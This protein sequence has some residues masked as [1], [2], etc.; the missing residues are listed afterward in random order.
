MNL[1]AKQFRLYFETVLF[2]LLFIPVFTTTALASPDTIK[3]STGSG[4][5]D[6][7]IDTLNNRI[8]ISCDNRRNNHMQG[9]IWMY[10]TQAGKARKLLFETPLGFNFHP[11]GIFMYTEN[12]VSYLYVINHIYKDKSEIDRFIVREQNLKLDKRITDI[13]GKPND[14][15]VTGKDE[16]YYTD[17]K[18]TGGSI[19]RYSNGQE[20]KVVK[21]LKMPN[22]IILLN[23]TLYFT[24]TLNGRLYK[25]SIA[26]FEKQTVCKLK[27]GDN[28]MLCGDDCFL[29]ASHQS[30]GKFRKHAKHPGVI[31]P[32]L[33]YRVNRHTGK[34]E[35]IFSD[36]GST[37][38]AVS[39]ALIYKNTLYLGQVFDGFI[40]VIKDF[41]I[42]ERE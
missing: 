40:L 14:L 15:V 30:F 7:A 32:S 25:T 23:D 17:Y 9:E 8:L 13:T 35:V 38:S 37:I 28:I 39:T 36:D 27:G 22:G 19:I 1:T 29:I 20:Q 2:S 5:E 11:H 12:G 3:V 18:M 26:S 24:T 4:P 6:L 31:S 10:D 34:K 41:E 16:F 33:V 21:G 42:K